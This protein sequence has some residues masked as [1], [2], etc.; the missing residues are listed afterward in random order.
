M[1]LWICDHHVKIAIAEKKGPGPLR[2]RKGK[3]CSRWKRR[4]VHG[5]RLSERPLQWAWSRHEDP[6]YRTEK[7]V[8][9]GLETPP[10]FHSTR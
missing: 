10:M 9:E 6:H 3:S 2:R 1:A 7:T 5:G 8:E 4:P